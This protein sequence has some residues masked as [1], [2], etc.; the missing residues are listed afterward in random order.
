MDTARFSI[1]ALAGAGTALVMCLAML[2][3]TCDDA[4]TLIPADTQVPPVASVLAQA[5]EVPSALDVD[6]DASESYDLDGTVVRYDWDFNDDG[7]YDQL[8]AG[9]TVQHTYPEAGTYRCTVRVHDD[10]NLTDEATVQ[11]TV[12]LAIAPPEAL[13]EAASDSGNPLLIRFDATASFDTDGEIVRYDWDMNNDGQFDLIDVG[14][15][16][17][18]VF[19]N[20]GIFQ[21][22]VRVFDN[23]GLSDIAMINFTISG[24][25]G[26]GIGLNPPNA[27]LVP[28]PDA[29]NPPLDITWDASGSSDPD[30]EIVR[31][32]W[33]MNFD[34][35]FE[36]NDAGPTRDIT[37]PDGGVYS[38]SVRV[39]DNDGGADIAFAS[40]DINF[41]PVALATSDPSS[42]DLQKIAAQM[43]MTG[44]GEIEVTF[45][46]SGSYDDD[47]E[48]VRYDWDL[49]N[50]GT[51]D[52]EDGGPVQTVVYD[53][54]GKFVVALRVH[55]NEGATD[56]ASAGVDVNEPP[57]ALLSAF[58]PS[59]T[60][61][62][63][64]EEEWVQDVSWNA[65][66]SFDP[67]GIIVQY[68]WD[69]DNDGTFE[70]VNGPEIVNT[71]YNASGIYTVSVRCTDNDGATEVA[72][73]TCDVNA[74]P[75]AEV[76]A[77]P[78]SGTLD[79]NE[80]E[81][82][83]LEGIFDASSSS[84]SD[85]EIVRYDWDLDNNGTF[86]VEDGGATQPYSYD[87]PGIYTIA[88]MVYDDDG[89]TAIA[90]AT[91]DVNDP[92][93]AVLTADYSQF[94]EHGVKQPSAQGE[95]S[96]FVMW[97][98]SGSTDSD[99][100]IVRYDWDLD[101]DSTFET[102]EGGSM[103]EREYVELGFYTV[104]VKVYDDDGA[105]DIAYHT[106][107]IE[108]MPP[109]ANL[110]GSTDPGSTWAFWNAG[111]SYD[112]DGVIT[113]YEWDLDNDGTYDDTT[114]QPYL[115]HDY[116]TFGEQ[117][118]TVRVTDN[119]GLTDTATA[120]VDLVS[121]PTADLIGTFSDE[122]EMGFEI[123]WDATGSTDIDGTI[124][125]YDWDFD[126]DGTYDLTGTNPVEYF[127]YSWQQLFVTAKVR[128][129]D[130]DGL[131]DTAT[132]TYGDIPQ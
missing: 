42:G 64:S 122:Q 40:V 129:T 26:L 116:G 74:P 103:V 128:V 63:N 111:T 31:Y 11:V 91:V 7:T 4:E 70:T 69:M 101:N 24:G 56:T 114:V 39:F 37:Y 6:F 86:E 132:Y 97:D 5:S 29:G 41:A 33:D 113:Q 130:D 108:G 18:H 55:D 23:D 89:A 53:A 51:F 119:D 96:F 76:F 45:D 36:I 27:V 124:V 68:D 10:D 3:C 77:D 22:R 127:V 66:G 110:S 57:T 93:N 43:R 102:T 73:A 47:G 65:D 59:G 52:V 72:T 95:S 105:T 58:P 61:E 106:F 32:D 79:W 117:T 35:V 123:E 34:G 104:G 120:T 80:L 48:V 85:G 25:G 100:T 2:G 78:P 112:P 81:E 71:T 54:S 49:N 60:L 131:T 15:N 98:A 75:V 126:N 46:G 121:A 84:D 17:E 13:G 94:E 125:Q 19:P 109:V 115:S 118:C 88:V 107:E 83:V 62:L 8:D 92:P 38:V 9:V 82:F 99:G 20:Y 14:P 16:P 30:G 67:D 21:V 87:M 90:Y 28:T 50:D 1:R 44:E 12:P